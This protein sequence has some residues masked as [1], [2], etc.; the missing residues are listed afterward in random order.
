MGFFL[1][2]YVRQ[3]EPWM[4]RT[5]ERTPTNPER[6]PFPGVS[7]ACAARLPEAA[8][9]ASFLARAPMPTQPSTLLGGARA[10][11]A[12]ESETKQ[13]YTN[14][15]AEILNS[16]GRITEVDVER[17]AVLC[18]IRIVFVLCIIRY[19]VLWNPDSNAPESD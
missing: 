18:I 9:S 11:Q 6:T 15:T 3:A 7:R 10:H 2:L 5:P 1:T 16:P 19:C 14:I 8:H 12:H 17:P 13:T 4:E